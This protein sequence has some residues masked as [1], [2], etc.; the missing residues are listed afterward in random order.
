[1]FIIG[2]FNVIKLL[3]RNTVNFE[4]LRNVLEKFGMFNKG[5]FATNE[6]FL[7]GRDYLLYWINWR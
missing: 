2:F 5:E 1:M 4:F 3:T 6:L 7:D